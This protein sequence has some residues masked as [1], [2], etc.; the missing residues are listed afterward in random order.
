M[1]QYSLSQFKEK[2][3]D[4]VWMNDDWTRA[5]T[6]RLESGVS[7]LTVFAYMLKNGD[8]FQMDE[9]SWKTLIQLGFSAAQLHEME[10][11]LTEELVGSK[12]TGTGM[13]DNPALLLDPF[14]MKLER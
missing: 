9:V 5:A 3:I 7:E 10:F 13:I 8:C 12:G 14:P 4:P 6:F 11:R 2:P 1:R